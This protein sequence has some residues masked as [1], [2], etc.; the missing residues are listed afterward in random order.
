MTQR[1]TMLAGIAALALLAG[2]SL[3]SAQEK[4]DQNAT[5]PAK[6][7]QAA[8]Q[9]DK[10]APA[11]KMGRVSKSGTKRRPRRRSRLR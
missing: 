2:T 9:M 8:Q 5:P 3:V 10:N 11:E 4:P 1:T 7:P 6:Q